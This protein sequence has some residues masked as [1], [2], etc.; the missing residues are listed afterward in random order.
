[1]RQKL[2]DHAKISATDALKTSLKRVI[3][4]TAEGT[5]DL[6]VNKIANS[7]TKVS[8]NP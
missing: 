3:Q 4:K 7:S 1:M 8:K 6:I 5:G 2:I